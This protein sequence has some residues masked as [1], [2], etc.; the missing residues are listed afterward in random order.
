MAA[1]TDLLTLDALRDE[2]RSLRAQLARLR[3]RLHR[4]LVLEL[5]TDAAIVLAATAAVL[6]F[7]DW[8]FRFGL[9]VRLVLLSSGVRRDSRRSWAFARSGGGG[10][11]GSTSCRWP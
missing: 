3:R 1:V 10:R 6:V 7:L 2:Q 9:P 4:Q 5:A 8:L 11:R